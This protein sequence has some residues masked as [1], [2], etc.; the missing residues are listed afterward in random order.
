MKLDPDKEVY[1]EAIVIAGLL[2]LV[3]YWIVKTLLK[4]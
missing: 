2:L 3:G 4:P 1:H